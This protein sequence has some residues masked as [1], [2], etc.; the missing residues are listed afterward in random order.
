MAWVVYGLAQLLALGF[1]WVAAGEIPQNTP[2]VNPSLLFWG[3][4]GGSEVRVE[5]RWLDGSTSDLVFSLRHADGTSLELAGLQSADSSLKAGMVDATEGSYCYL[6]FRK[7]ELTY[8]VYAGLMTPAAGNS[9]GLAGLVV[10]DSGLALE[11][12]DFSST[13]E[14]RL[15]AELFNQLAL[16]PDPEGFALPLAADPS[17]VSWARDILDE[18]LAS[19]EPEG[20]AVANALSFAGEA[21]VNGR[22]GYLFTRPAGGSGEGKQ[23]VVDIGGRIFFRN[24][25]DADWARLVEEGGKDRRME[26]ES[27]WS[28]RL[29]FPETNHPAIDAR[30]QAWVNQMVATSLA[31]AGDYYDVREGD[32]GWE[33]WLDYRLTNPPGEA[34]SVVFERGL[35]PA[36]SAHPTS[37]LTVLNFSTHSGEPL[38]LTEIFQLPEQALAIFARRAPELLRQWLANIQE[39]NAREEPLFSEG[40]APTWENYRAFG[41]EPE[42]VR[43]Y[44]QEYQVLPYVFGKPE[45]FLPLADLLPAQP[46]ALLWPA[47]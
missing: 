29:A 34:L 8:T 1:S 27:L 28:V 15:G 6:Q 43:L 14:S 44:F 31:E 16:S 7:T 21:E 22:T 47:K 5:Q 37:Q 2:P 23:Y 19:Q 41:L 24:N 38:A 33:L 39:D 26:S 18:V 13:Y 30:L 20:D 40:L 4:A 11:I 12:L 35:N 10:E 32:S 3:A 25:G 36:H 9:G 46:A 45:I 17:S 42:G